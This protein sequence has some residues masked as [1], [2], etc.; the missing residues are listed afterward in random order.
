[1]VDVQTAIRPYLWFFTLSAIALGAYLLA[2]ITNFFVASALEKA[3]PTI[4]APLRKS[5]AA[6]AISGSGFDY[7]SILRGNLFD[8]T[9]GVAAPAFQPRRVTPMAV[10]VPAPTPVAPKIPL[11]LKLIG[12]VIGADSPPYAVIEDTRL[13]RQF[14]YRVN[15]FV[16]EDARIMKIE[17]NR[18]LIIRGDEEIV[19]DL[20]GLTTTNTPSTPVNAPAAIPTSIV[21]PADGVR[22]MGR[23][24]WIVD[25][26]EIDYAVSHLPELLTKARV[27]PNFVD[28]KPDGFRIFAIRPDSLYAK[29][30][31][32]NGDVLRQVNDVDV[33]NPTNFTE[34]FNQLKDKETITINLMRDNQDMLLHYEIRR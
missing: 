23:S 1:L 16:T 30:G 22:S 3:V 11:Q 26:S 25:R 31:L 14:L 24:H 7:R 19:L 4:S 5:P 8:P 20:T 28:G 33:R 2:D 13:R 18:V 17:R 15:D 29:I 34:V 21:P 9:L 27:I 6:I 12:T 10:P 32:Q